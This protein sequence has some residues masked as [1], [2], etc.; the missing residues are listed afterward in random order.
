M[1]YK[2][3]QSK[4]ERKNAKR[5][6]SFVAV[7]L[8]AIFS[9]FP[10]AWK[11]FS[12]FANDLSLPFWTTGNTTGSGI[13]GFFSLMRSKQSLAE[14]NSALSEEISALKEK[15]SGYDFVV[16]DNLEMKQTLFGDPK[17]YSVARIISRPNISAYDT[18]IL[19][20]GSDRGIQKGSKVLSGEKTVI[21]TVEE[22]YSQSSKVR[23][24][25]TAGQKVNVLLGPENIPAEILGMGGGFF[26]VEIPNG[27]DVKE[28]DIAV[29]AENSAYVV[30]TVTSKEKT[31]TDSF[32]KFYLESP[33]KIFVMKYVEVEKL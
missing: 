23:L 31:D 16:Q 12:S 15:L 25:S 2:S 30:A 1:S 19:D 14:Q 22:T 18:F 27:A 24:F 32:Q 5:I 28:G 10:S 4:K 21:G 11:M 6:F 20:A 26:T 9:F 29:L 17:K 8:L 13:S 7:F 3:F 33:A